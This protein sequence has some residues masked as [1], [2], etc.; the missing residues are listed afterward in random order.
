MTTLLI[1]PHLTHRPIVKLA[2][3]GSQLTD[4]NEFE[5]VLLNGR[6]QG[7]QSSPQVIDSLLEQIKKMPK[8]QLI[9]QQ[10]D[11]YLFRKKA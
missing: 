8:F 9:Y 11:V 2:T 7:W 10:D 1:A 6:H 5:Y 4:L 3:T